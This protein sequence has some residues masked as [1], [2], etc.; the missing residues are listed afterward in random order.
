VLE[1]SGEFANGQMV[2]AGSPP[3]RDGRTLTRRIT[4]TPNADGSVRQLWETSFDGGQTWQT[5]FDGHYTRKN[6]TVGRRCSRTPGHSEPTTSG[7]RMPTAHSL[8]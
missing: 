1:L 7:R 6:K 3:T 2:L 8:W 5:A 4:W